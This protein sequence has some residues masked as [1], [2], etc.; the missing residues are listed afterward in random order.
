MKYN[1]LYIAFILGLILA[2][3]YVD[4]N[5]PKKIDWTRTFKSTDKN[6]FGLE[7]FHKI[8]P[9]FFPDRAVE[10]VR[11]P[12]YNLLTE[13]K[14]PQKSNY[15]IIDQYLGEGYQNKGLSE[16]DVDKLMDYAADGNYLFIASNSFPEKLLDTLN[17]KLKQANLA[18]VLK[19]KLNPKLKPLKIRLTNPVFKNKTAELEK[20]SSEAYFVS[21][22]TLGVKVLAVNDSSKANFIS[23][24]VGK[25]KLFLL[26]VPE[27]FCNYYLL[28]DDKNP[29]ATRIISYLPVLPTY[30]DEYTKQG[31]L[32]EES[33]FRF[34]KSKPALYWVYYLCLY[35]MLL[36][37]FFE[38]KRT[39]RIIP[40]IN[41]KQNTTLDFIRTI[42]QLYYHKKDNISLAAKKVEY[43]KWTI[44][45]KTGIRFEGYSEEFREKL[46][47]KTGVTRD[48]IK[49]LTEWMESIDSSQDISDQDLITF[50]QMV[51]SFHKKTL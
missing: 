35:G 29:I 50:N 23:Y 40:V 2:I 25:G 51:E 13:G 44:L 14:L 49:T 38:G 43:L 39:Q 12:A 22:D 7:I 46:A 48:E 1:K 31:R 36:Y 30:Y 33:V 42:G 41:P 45:K 11:I 16:M 10:T 4:Y 32:G 15:I 47:H 17:L 28:K 19:N 9:E 21:K 3:V 27:V 20:E 6:P 26:S 18:S 37:L 5:T 24:Q 8:L 34:M